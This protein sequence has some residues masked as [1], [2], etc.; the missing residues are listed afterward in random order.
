MS[1]RWWVKADRLGVIITGGP[2]RWGLALQDIWAHASTSHAEGGDKEA[3]NLLQDSRI[4]L[5]L[6]VS[7][8]PRSPDH[9]PG[10]LLPTSLGPR[11]AWT[12]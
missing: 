9:P 4:L 12:G 11:P 6:R 10:P 2:S 7:G 1:G 3:Q 5:T 8:R